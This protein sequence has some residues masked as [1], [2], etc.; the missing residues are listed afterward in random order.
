M[1]AR[2]TR[3][4]LR[5]IIASAALFALTV[6]AVAAAQDKSEKPAQ[7]TA[8][9]NRQQAA[10]STAQNNANTH[11]TGTYIQNVQDYEAQRTAVA[12][13]RADYEARLEEHR[14][15]Q[16]AYDQAYARWQADVAAC[17]AGDRTRCAATAPVPK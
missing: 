15:A 13:A 1:T 14:R 5:A 9:L 11:S 7:G 2:P 8:D 3:H 12:Q 16:A 10:A 6:P 17:N 4:A